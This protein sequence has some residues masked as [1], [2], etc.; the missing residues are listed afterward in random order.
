MYEEV[1]LAGLVVPKK[2]TKFEHSRNDSSHSLFGSPTYSKGDG[3]TSTTKASEA[4]E[5]ES[6][7]KNIFQRK[8]KTY[9]L[10]IKTLENEDQPEITS[11]IFKERIP[12]FIDLSQVPQSSGID[13]EGSID[14]LRKQNLISRENSKIE[15]L[16]NFS[17][18]KKF[19]S[20]DLSGTQIHTRRHSAAHSQDVQE[21]IEKK[22]SNFGKKAN[23][24]QIDTHILQEALISHQGQDNEEKLSEGSIKESKSA[25]ILSPKDQTEN[26]S[27]TTS[28][29]EDNEDNCSE[30]PPM[31]IHSKTMASVPLK[32]DLMGQ[33]KQNDKNEDLQDL[34][35]SL[36]RVNK[37]QIT[38]SDEKNNNFIVNEP[39]ENNIE[40]DIPKPFERKRTKNFTQVINIKEPVNAFSSAK[41]KS[42][43]TITEK[44]I[45]LRK[46]M[47]KKKN[48]IKL[49]EAIREKGKMMKNQP[50]YHKSIF[51]NH[52]FFIK[53]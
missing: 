18:Q 15:I 39:Q 50:P 43:K 7:E 28:S 34:I 5:I 45:R 44:M 47:N 24:Y 19:L 27:G 26:I 49:Y 33:I 13:S 6:F 40:D 35:G 37:K 4:M 36:R 30:S 11:G 32:F 21:V 51:F 25:N 38:N 53:F 9:F 31:I 8:E 1:N 2:N 3:L 20:P 48:I 29:S 22:L 52:K 10:N 16:S 42:D 41:T 23:A 14:S 46:E 12:V 17:P